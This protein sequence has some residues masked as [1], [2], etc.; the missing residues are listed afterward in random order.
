MA[1]GSAQ[2]KRLRRIGRFE[3][4]QADQ[5]DAAAIAR[6][7]GSIEPSAAPRDVPRSAADVERMLQTG[8][9]FLVAE[10][11]G[12]VCGVVRKSEDEG[13]AWFDLLASAVPGAA[14]ALVRSV[15][16]AA[17]ERGLRLARSRVPDGRLVDYVGWLG[18]FPVSREAVD[19]VPILVME[20]RLPLLTVRDQRR[21]DA[22]FIAEMTG[23]DSY[24]FELGARPGWL[25]AADGD[26]AVGVVWVSDAGGGEGEIATP[27]LLASHRGR[28][29]ELWMLER[30]VFHAEH[31]GYHT[32]RVQTDEWLA[33]LTREL[34]ERGWHRDGAT[35]VRRLA[36]PPPETPDW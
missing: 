24:A 17:Q 16:M 27:V 8:H 4:R 23:L 5:D 30:A 13:V 35:F 3:I 15:E 36:A 29:L 25:I 11:E 31:A 19:G 20:R 26:R 14:R 22:E 1:D 33:P 34:E 28:G 10:R 21:E 9:L 7:L 32:A 6:L 2:A 12:M 18:Y